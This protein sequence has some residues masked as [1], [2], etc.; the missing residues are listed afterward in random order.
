MKIHIFVS[1]LH[2]QIPVAKNPALFVADS[3]LFKAYRQMYLPRSLL[4]ADIYGSVII[5]LIIGDDC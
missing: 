5:L 4:I 3:A 1:D 2:Y